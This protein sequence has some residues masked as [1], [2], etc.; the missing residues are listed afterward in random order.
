MNNMQI[1]NLINKIMKN[2]FKMEYI[3]DKVILSFTGKCCIYY[4][5]YTCLFLFVLLT[6][7]LGDRSRC[8]L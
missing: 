2:N 1:C 3:K 5:H 6:F 8:K 4:V 7:I